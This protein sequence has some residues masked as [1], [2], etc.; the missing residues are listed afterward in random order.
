MKGSI[1][2]R[3]DTGD[4]IGAGKSW[5]VGNADGVF[6]TTFNGGL[7]D[8]TYRGDDDWDLTFAAPEGQHLM[9]GIYTNATR[10][11]FNSPVKPGLSVSGAG[12]GCNTLTG[13]FNIRQ[14]I[15]SGTQLKRLLVDFEQ[16]CEGGVPALS[17]T[18]DLTAM[19]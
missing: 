1:E 2:F 16:H 12:R 18:I 5:S 10:S 19:E 9:N 14:I 13:Q 15:S 11:P 8:V 6:T 4:Y 17:G 7:A 3:S